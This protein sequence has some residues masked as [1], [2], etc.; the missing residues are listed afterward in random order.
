[1]DYLNEF[2]HDLI[3]EIRDESTVTG[4]PLAE[5]AFERLCSILETEGEIET[6]DS[7]VYRGM[8]SGKSLRIDGHGGDPRDAEGV[9]SVI[10]CEVFEEDAPVTLNAA[11]AKRLFGHAANFIAAARKREFRD[12]LHLESPEYGVATMIAEVLIGA[13]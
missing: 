8:M 13:Q 2:Y 4:L 7:G 12:G 1:M 11:E 6:A 9:L 10:V 3:A 5:V